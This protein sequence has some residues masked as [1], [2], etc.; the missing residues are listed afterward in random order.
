MKRKFTIACTL[1]FL[2]LVAI[3][4]SASIILVDNNTCSIGCDN[5]LFQDGDIGNPLQA[6]TQN[7]SIITLSQDVADGNLFAPSNGQARVEQEAGL[8]YH[9][10]FMDLSGTTTTLL[11]FTVQPLM[12]QDAQNGTLADLTGCHD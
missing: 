12:G 8:D 5:I 6:S 7:G 4:A 1:V 2:T 10:L 3:P 11:Q 9:G